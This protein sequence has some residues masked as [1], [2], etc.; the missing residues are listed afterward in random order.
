MSNGK[1]NY[2]FNNEIDY[3]KLALDIFNELI[4]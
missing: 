1:L 4:V 2:V 3:E